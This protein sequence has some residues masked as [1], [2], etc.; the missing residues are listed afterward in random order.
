MAEPLTP[1]TRW[2]YPKFTKGVRL[3]T[4]EDITKIAESTWCLTIEGSK[5]EQYV[6]PNYENVF[7]SPVD[8]MEMARRQLL[9]PKTVVIVAEVACEVDNTDPKEEYRGLSVQGVV[10][11]AVLGL[12][13]NSGRIGQFFVKVEADQRADIFK[14]FSQKRLENLDKVLKAGCEEYGHC[15]IPPRWVVSM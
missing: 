5:L 9:D 2:P 12:P 1:K 15:R 4:A 8:G 10:G 14:K 13:E 11:V 3:A 6:R 7:N